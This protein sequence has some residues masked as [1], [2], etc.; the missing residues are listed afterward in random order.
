MENRNIRRLK[1]CILATEGIFVLS[2]ALIFAMDLGRQRSTLESPIGWLCA[3]SGLLVLIASFFLPREH[4][5]F[6]TT[7][8][9]I[10]FCGAVAGILLPRL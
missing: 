7:A 5:R 8:W 9:L 2:L 10:L 6:A 3:L 1:I 4:R